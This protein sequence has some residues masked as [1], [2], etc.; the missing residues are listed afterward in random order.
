MK[1]LVE[2]TFTL[3]ELLVV[4]AIIAILA[5]ML[6]PALSKAR[7]KARSIS[8]ASN[9]KQLCLAEVMYADEYDDMFIGTNCSWV[10]NSEAPISSNT[11]FCK[12]PSNGRWYYGWPN[13]IYP[14]VGDF[15][16]YKCPSN[17]TDIYGTNYGTPVGFNLSKDYGSMF[18]NPKSRAL[19]KHPSDTLVLG[20]KWGGGGTPYILSRQYY[21]MKKVHN[22]TANCGYIDGHVANWKVVDSD[23]GPV[24]VAGMTGQV[25]QAADRSS[26]SYPWHVVNEAFINWN[27]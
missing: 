3:I 11:A 25:W 17:Q 16:P 26:T 2:F 4:I 22:D 9:L 6:L 18:Y 23:I 10:N 5:A 20:S 27:K 14:Y 15:A 7:E 19:F 24:E 8:C 12:H 21:C 1:K 13:F